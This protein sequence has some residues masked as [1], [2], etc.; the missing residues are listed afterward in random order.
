VNFYH[1][2]A[3]GVNQWHWNFNNEG[4]STV[5]S[6]SYIFSLFGNKQIELS[7]SNGVCSDTASTNVLLDNTLKAA[8]GY[9]DILC[10]QDQAVF[11]D[12]S[13]GKITS[14]NWDFA[15]GST[16]NEKN[17]QPQSYPLLGTTRSKIYTIQLVVENNLQC[18]DTVKHAMKV[19]N[20]CFITVPNAFT[21]NGDGMNDYLYP[22]NAWKA[23]HLEFFI[24]N[25]YGQLVFHTTDWTQKW[26]GT[27]NGIRQSTGVYVWMLRY[28]DSET[29]QHYLRRGTT[30]LIR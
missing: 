6:P 3:N 12:S 20:S 11:T 27:I 15:N 17:P 7:V 30:V 16:G 25:R 4:S 8:F 2:G 23:T 18:Y 1:N 5:Q 14:W 28:T 19:V 22:L 13:I 26:D 21:P 29:G 9:P 10:P 24:Y